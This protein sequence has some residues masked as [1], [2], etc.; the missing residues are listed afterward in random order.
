[1]DE[2]DRCRYSTPISG[3]IRLSPQGDCRQSP[4]RS[5]RWGRYGT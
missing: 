2:G 5:Q 4:W 1:M 3:A